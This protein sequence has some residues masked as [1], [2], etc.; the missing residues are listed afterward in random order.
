MQRDEGSYI[1]Q[2]LIL[3]TRTALGTIQADECIGHVSS[4]RIKE[5]I[6]DDPSRSET[7]G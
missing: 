7:S 2:K 5:N 1:S 3:E 4:V 6:K